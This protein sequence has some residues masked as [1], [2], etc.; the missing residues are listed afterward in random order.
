[1]NSGVYKIANIVTNDFYIGSSVQLSVRRNQ[2]FNQLSNNTHNNKHLQNSFNKH[3]SSNFIFEILSTCPI[4]YCLKLE[5][6]FI[7]NLKPIYNQL[8]TAGNSLGYKH[9]QNSLKKLKSQNKE[10]C[11]KKLYQY[12]NQQLIKIWNS[13]NEYAKYYNVNRAAVYKALRKGHQCAGYTISI[14]PASLC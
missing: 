11:S 6:W 14:Q 3:S 5:Q 2:H 10:Y 9:N 8:P 7:D 1:M 12:N 4:E 13:C